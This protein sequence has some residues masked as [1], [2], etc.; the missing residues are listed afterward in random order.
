MG[1]AKWRQASDPYYGKRPKQESF[2]SGSQGLKTEREGQSFGGIEG[3]K[4]VLGERGVVATSPLRHYG[5]GGFFINIDATEVRSALL[6]FDKMA[7]PRSNIFEVGLDENEDDF[8]SSC[9]FLVKP[10]LNVGDFVGGGN[11]IVNFHCETILKAYLELERLSPGRWSWIR[12]EREL[13]GEEKFMGEA[14][15]GAE[16]RLY[17]AIPIPAGNAPLNEILEFKERR[18]DELLLLRKE[19]DDLAYS[20]ISS[21][22]DSGVLAGAID[23]VDRACRDVIKVGKESKVPFRLGDLAAGLDIAVPVG[24][25]AFAAAAV[26]NSGVSLSAVAEAVGGYCTVSLL[27]GFTSRRAK[28]ANHPFRYVYRTHEFFS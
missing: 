26:V 6:Y 17:R 13:P 22:G 11:D 19:I 16:L 3:A 25:V 12:D 14:D 27:K 9:G 1:E 24:P 4:L 20:V 10:T 7:M 15:S 18:R 8:L 2:P 28:L 23:E 5:S 21:G